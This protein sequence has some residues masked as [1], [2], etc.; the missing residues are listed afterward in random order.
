MDQ[1]N[2]KICVTLQWYSVGNPESSYAQVRLFARKKED[3]NCQQNVDVKYNFE[4]FICLL[5][6]KKSVY[7]KVFAYKS[8]Y[9]VL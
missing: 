6:G 9:M 1:P 4:E 3:K 2:R 5:D 7:H 8:I